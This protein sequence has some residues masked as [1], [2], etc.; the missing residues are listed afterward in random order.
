MLNDVPVGG[1]ASSPGSNYRPGVCPTSDLGMAFSSHSAD[2]WC[3]T[4]AQPAG[5][6]TKWLLLSALGSVGILC[7]GQDQECGPPGILLGHPSLRGRMTLGGHDTVVQLSLFFLLG[8]RW[9]AHSQG[10]AVKVKAQG[11]QGSPAAGQ[12]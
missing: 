1:W 3:P 9:W 11:D 5:I 8:G 4:G 2:S 7:S 6:D 12:L 10:W